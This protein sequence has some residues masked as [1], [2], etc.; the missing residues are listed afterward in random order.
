MSEGKDDKV[1]E[2][3][4]ASSNPH[5]PYNTSSMSRKAY[6][7]ESAETWDQRFYT[8]K[9]AAF[10][11]NLVPRFGLKPG[12]KVLDVGTGTGILIPFLLK[13]IGPYGSVT[14]I[15]FAERMVQICRSKYSHIKNVTVKLHD[16]EEEDLPPACFD[17]AICFGVFPHLEK[18][19]KALRNL[20]R[21]LKPGG[22][23]IIAHALSSQEIKDHHKKA[24]S[25]VASDALPEAPEMKRLLNQ[26]GFI[27]IY[28]EDKP[29]GYLCL[30]RKR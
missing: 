29:G 2:L 19:E 15:D 28:I 11:E 30:S 5:P 18:K 4:K 8:P 17:A 21:A 23:L 16:V 20:N 26:A 14:A 10:L 27:E 1:V 7:N 3:F 9:L 24:L 25:A 12:Y 13:A 6:F 22:I